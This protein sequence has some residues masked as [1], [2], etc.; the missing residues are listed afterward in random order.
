MKTYYAAI[1]WENDITTTYKLRK[2]WE[3]AAI[4]ADLLFALHHNPY[5]KYEEGYDEE[6]AKNA[7]QIVRLELD[8]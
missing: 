6:R 4:D 5:A 3:Q 8:D 7:I 2:T 1:Y